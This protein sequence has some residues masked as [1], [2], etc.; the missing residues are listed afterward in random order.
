AEVEELTTKHD[1]GMAALQAE[2]DARGAVLA[3]VEAQLAEARAQIATQT[4]RIGDLEQTL[5]GVRD[6][7]KEARAQI[8]AHTQRIA[9]L[10]QALA[11]VRDELAQARDKIEKD[12]QRA[13]QARKALAV[14]T[15]LLDEQLARP[16]DGVAGKD[17]SAPTT[18]AP[19]SAKRSGR[20]G[21]GG[22]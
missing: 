8:A 11:G 5:A 22:G 18:I 14:A 7:L 19:G 9:E 4:R 15:A 21:R 3:Q 2:F 6:E 10:E 1:A 12:R 20:A 17:K 16:A 13:E